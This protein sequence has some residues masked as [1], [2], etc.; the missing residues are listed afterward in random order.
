MEA[1]L[2]GL[3]QNDDPRAATL[4]GELIGE[5]PLG[6]SALAQA[7]SLA[8]TGNEEARDV[9]TKD[10]KAASAAPPTSKPRKSWKK[11]D[12]PPQQQLPPPPPQISRGFSSSS[13][14]LDMAGPEANPR[15][16]T[17]EELS[18]SNGMGG[19]N[20]FGVGSS[21]S[22]GMG[23]S[24]YGS[25]SFNDSLGFDPTGAVYRNNSDDGSPAS[26]PAASPSIFGG[27]DIPS[28]APPPATNPRL[29]PSGSVPLS[30]SLPHASHLT[31]QV[32]AASSP[33]QR[34]RL[35]AQSPLLG[36]SQLVGTDVTE[37]KSMAFGFGAQNKQNMPATAINHT[38]TASYTLSEEAE[39]AQA[40][41]GNEETTAGM[42]ELAD[43]VG[44][45]SLN[46][47][48]EVRYHGR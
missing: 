15:W 11:P 35:N 9:L 27:I 43:V 8:L 14:V 47:N 6:C 13:S 2:G 1:L 33:R 5:L 26:V 20:D 19:S 17:D 29:T 31:D 30:L 39:L 4:L 3:L 41:D 37:L 45:L 48:A 38:G 21:G 44:Q 12:D 40:G 34:R 32:G 10:L 16:F 28:S 7:D 42:S 22:M 25:G 24:P 18:F 36:T 23:M 46:E